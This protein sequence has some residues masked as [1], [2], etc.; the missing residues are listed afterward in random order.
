MIFGFFMPINKFAV[1]VQQRYTSKAANDK[2][3]GIAGE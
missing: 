2:R 3:S 1:N